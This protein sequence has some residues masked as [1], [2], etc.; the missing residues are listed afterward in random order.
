MLRRAGALE[1]DAEHERLIRRGLYLM[2]LLDSLLEQRDRFPEPVVELAE[3]M[4]P[5]GCADPVEG[6]AWMKTVQAAADG[7]MG[8]DK[9]MRAVMSTW[10]EGVNDHEALAGEWSAALVSRLDGELRER[11]VARWGVPA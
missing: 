2:M 7:E 4:L 11:L 10:V 1:K 5:A 6:A 9:G 3:V 8:I